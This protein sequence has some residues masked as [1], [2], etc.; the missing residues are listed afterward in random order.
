MILLD[1]HTH[2]YRCFDRSIFYDAAARN[3]NRIKKN[4]RLAPETP[5]VLVLTETANDDEFERLR[6][7][8]TGRG[9]GQWTVEVC[10]EPQFLQLL[11]P[12]GF[13][14]WILAG[15]QIQTLERL[16]VL[17]IGSISRNLE[18]QP[19]QAV[20]QGVRDEGALPVLPWGVG[21]WFGARGHHIRA[22]TAG[23]P[24]PFLALG[25]NGGRPWIWP[26]SPVI[27][28]WEKRQGWILSGSDPLPLPA[29]QTRAG[30]FGQIL[31]HDL[32]LDYPWSVFSA[33]LQSCPPHLRFFGRPSGLLH[34]LRS[35]IAL[36]I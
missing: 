16:E 19:L 25:D 28:T 4:S 1:A 6:A 2:V 15:R 7:E 8:R 32:D 9:P 26:R 18:K 21:K 13:R 5:A 35:Q 30:S 20:I 29:E 36:R 34:F 12:E 31:D 14:L 27:K 23:G 33:W 22:C 11:H 24:N 17:A 3:F 10:A